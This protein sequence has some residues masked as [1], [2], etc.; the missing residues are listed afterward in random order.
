MAVWVVFGIFG[1][2]IMVLAIVVAQEHAANRKYHEQLY[3]IDDDL[4]RA[5]VKIKKMGQEIIK[6]NQLLTETTSRTRVVPVQPVIPPVP[7]TSPRGMPKVPRGKH[8][9]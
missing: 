8:S 5:E 2:A 4:A 3:D 1:F 9:G 6:L 7:T